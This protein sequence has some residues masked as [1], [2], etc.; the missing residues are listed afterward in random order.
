M[1]DC[2]FEQNVTATNTIYHSAQY[3]SKITLPSVDKDQL[4]EFDLIEAF[5]RNFPEMGSAEEVIARYGD[6]AKDLVERFGRRFLLMII[7]KF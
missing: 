5:E 3:P 6:L 4:P 7:D 2:L 1:L